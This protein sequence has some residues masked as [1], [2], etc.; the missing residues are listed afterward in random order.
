M[1][2]KACTKDVERAFGILQSRFS[3]VAGPVRFWHKHVLHDIMYT[4][5]IMHNMIIA[6]KRDVDASIE[7][8]METLTPVVKMLLDENIRFQQFLARHREIRNKD[9]H[10]A[11]RNALIDHLWDE[12]S[13]SNN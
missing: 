12:Y 9:A 11:L 10:I 3:I 6:D 4:C 2:Q 13:N 7:D 5:I 8:R 1:K